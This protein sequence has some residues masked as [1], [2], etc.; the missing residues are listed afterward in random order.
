MTKDE[1]EQAQEA[2]QRRRKFSEVPMTSQTE[3]SSAP[4]AAEN[5]RKPMELYLLVRPIGITMAVRVKTSAGEKAHLKKS[6]LKH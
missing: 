3:F 2:I 1:Y 5:L 4:I 6:S